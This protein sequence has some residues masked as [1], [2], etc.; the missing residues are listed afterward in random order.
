MRRLILGF[1]VASTS[2]FGSAI[3][4]TDATAFTAN[5]VVT[6][7]QLG[8]DQTS[9][10][11]SFTVLSQ[12]NTSVQGS[13]YSGGGKVLSAGTDW[14]TSGGLPANDALLS[15][16]DGSKGN[17]PLTFSFNAPVAGAGAL[18]QG[19]G[20]TSFTATIEAFSGVNSILR[21]TLTSDWAGDA[22]FLGVSSDAF[23]ITSVVYSIQG[24]LSAGSLMGHTV[25][26]SEN[27]V[28]GDLRLRDP[29][30]LIVPA[31]TPIILG[32]L[33][34]SPDPEPSMTGVVLLSLLAFGFY[35]RK[36]AF[37]AS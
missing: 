12:N 30:V 2:V 35:A 18:I 24:K 10:S 26:G 17:A 25:T 19:F 4:V 16:S 14:G 15:T 27:F 23:D 11:P 28:V 34:A 37:R 9:I 3:A 36:Y 29:S 22:M 32:P 13:L 6:W 5:D 7:N 20:G 33:V 1:L 31:Q 21:T 8:A